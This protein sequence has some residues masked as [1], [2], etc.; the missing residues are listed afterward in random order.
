MWSILGKNTETAIISGVQLGIIFEIEGY[1]SY[2]KT[3]YGAISVVLTGGD[4]E[5]FA[6]Q[7]N[8]TVNVEPY[9]VFKGL[10]RII[11]YNANNK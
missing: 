4:S 3:Q 10:N 1:I 8:H 5:I 7:I 9:L 6:K 2:F 11:Q